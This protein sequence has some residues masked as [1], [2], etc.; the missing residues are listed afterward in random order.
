[1]P[2][3]TITL[4]R[5]KQPLT[6]EQP[7]EKPLHDPLTEIIKSVANRA[8]ADMNE[9]LT[10][11]GV[12]G[13]MSPGPFIRFFDPV[14]NAFGDGDTFIV[15]SDGVTLPRYPNS[16]NVFWSVG[17]TSG[18]ADDP[19]D[20][21][22]PELRTTTEAYQ[23]WQ[24]NRY[25]YDL[26]SIDARGDWKTRWNKLI[27]QT[28][29]QQHWGK[30]L[31]DFQ[32]AHQNKSLYYWISRI[33]D[34]E[35]LSSL[36]FLPRRRIMGLTS[37]NFSNDEATRLRRAWFNRYSLRGLDLDVLPAPEYGSPTG[38]DE[39]ADNALTGIFDSYRGLA[40]PNYQ[41]SG[42]APQTGFGIGGGGEFVGRQPDVN[43]SFSL[44][45][46]WSVHSAADILA[47]MDYTSANGTALDSMAIRDK[48]R[49]EFVLKCNEIAK[50]NPNLGIP[51][52]EKFMLDRFYQDF[53]V[54][55]FQVPSY[56]VR[57]NHTFENLEGYGEPGQDISFGLVNPEYNYFF[58]TYEEGIGDPQLPEA[59]LPNLYIYSLLQKEGD[60]G[61]NR[62]ATLGWQNQRDQRNFQEV[63]NNYDKTVTD[64]ATAMEYWLR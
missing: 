21:Q 55:N 42:E 54:C 25:P 40:D 50:R 56:Y 22:F 62:S 13:G 34:Y 18:E 28:K 44:T 52:I 23:R 30:F 48:E 5:K 20:I 41:P 61:V 64:S 59:V 33:T 37:A 15:E 19:N 46:R 39:G 3:R 43:D 26:T 29:R 9:Y 60:L 35:S 53:E 32:R 49:F 58:K 47:Y 8:G 1:M 10:R 36:I 11:G 12:R 31:V 24:G 63:Q 51:D 14:E 4:E 27:A 17:E 16:V 2:N 7:V 38:F 45:G 57:N 6:D